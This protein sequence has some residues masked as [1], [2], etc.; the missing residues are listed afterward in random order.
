MSLD[1]D[2]DFLGYVDLHSRTER[3]LFSREDIL[4][5]IK[6]ANIPEGQYSLPLGSFISVHASEARP[7][8]ERARRQLKRQT[9]QLE[10]PFKGDKG[11]EDYLL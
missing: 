4:R 1:S 6:L 9:S 2:D 5:L 7:L 11:A 8:I 3:A 10:L